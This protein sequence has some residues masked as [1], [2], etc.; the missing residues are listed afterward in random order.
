MSKII[1]SFFI[2][3]LILFLYIH[4]CYH[5]KKSNELEIYELDTIYKDKIEEICNLRQPVVFDVSDYCEKLIETTNKN[6]IDK[7]YSVFNINIRNIKEEND[8]TEMYLPFSINLANK[9]FEED[10]DKKYITE[11]NFDFL[12]ETGIIK[13]IQYN[14]FIFRPPLVSNCNYDYLYSS[15]NSNT[16]FRYEVNYRNYFIITQG[17]V[18]IKLSPPKSIKYLH[19]INDYEN[20]EFKTFINPWDVKPEHLNDFNKIKCLE[21]TLTQGKCIHIP[22]YWFYSFQMNNTS[23]IISLKYRTYMNNLTISPEIVMSFLQNKNITRNYVKKLNSNVSIEFD[24]INKDINNDINDNNIDNN[25]NNDIN[26]DINKDNNITVNAIDTST[27][28]IFDLP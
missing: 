18:K 9:L 1:I 12:K 2:F 8:D 6:Y 15:K 19:V 24:N 3:C 10:N 27:T 25:I 20:F 17:S 21:I 13:N 14:D 28:S 11:N 7:N 4:I 5:L 26:K 23:S 16:P 22:P